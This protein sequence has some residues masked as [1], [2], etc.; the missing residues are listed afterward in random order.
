MNKSKNE[1]KEILAQLLSLSME[2]GANLIKPEYEQ[3]LY[4][5]IQKKKNPDSYIA[6]FLSGSIFTTITPYSWNVGNLILGQ[7][8]LQ[9]NFVGE[10]KYREAISYLLE[11]YNA[12]I[13]QEKQ[14]LIAMYWIFKANSIDLKKDKKEKKEKKMNHLL[15][16]WFEDAEIYIKCLIV[17]AKADEYVHESEK[18]YIQ[19]Q[20]EIFGINSEE[21]WKENLSVDDFDFTHISTLAK[22][23]ILRDLI[24]IAYI[25]GRYDPR[26]KDKI[27]L[28]ASKMSIEAETLNNLENWCHR[29]F[30]LIQ[31]SAIF[32]EME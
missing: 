9:S 8:I 22:I 28:Y 25:D 20:S 7:K 23:S 21:L 1:L 17:I 30:N 5:E 12:N 14:M 27:T 4:L 3:E 24:V 13:I 31:E 2:E 29:Y 26:E 15:Y 18:E 32:F 19:M 16:P 10:K 6:S 11:K